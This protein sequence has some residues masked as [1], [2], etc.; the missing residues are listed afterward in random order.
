MF[1][2]PHRQYLFNK[3]IPEFKLKKNYFKLQKKYISFFFFDDSVILKNKTI[4]FFYFWNNYLFQ[5][6]PNIQF[7]FFF[8]KFFKIK[9]LN[10]LAPF[11][12]FFLKLKFYGKTFKWVFNKKKIKFRI[13]KPHRSQILFKYLKFK[14]KRKLKFKLRILCNND[15]KTFINLIKQIKYLNIFTKKGMR[16]LKTVYNKK[17]GKVSG[18]M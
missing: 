13:Q 10:I 16:V 7:H 11:R 18:Y 8:N 9:Y 12:Y 2:K 6:Y 5:K 15:K 14:K 3:K 1:N 4:N 17:K